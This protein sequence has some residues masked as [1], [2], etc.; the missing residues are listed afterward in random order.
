MTI[1]KKELTEEK[2]H[3]KTERE[4]LVNL[5]VDHEAKIRD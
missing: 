1:A 5:K 4:Q 3:L 2:A